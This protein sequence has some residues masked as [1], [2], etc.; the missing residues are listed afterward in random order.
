MYK[1]IYWSLVVAR[2]RIG[3]KM[4]GRIRY[5]IREGLEDGEWPYSVRTGE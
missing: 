2:D 1:Y 4:R 3:N 5:R